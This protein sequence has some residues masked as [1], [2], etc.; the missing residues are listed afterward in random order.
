MS[1]FLTPDEMQ[2]IGR[3]RGKFNAVLHL[4]QV[5]SVDYDIARRLV[6]KYPD[7]VTMVDRMLNEINEMAHMSRA[8]ICVYAAKHKIENFQL[9]SKDQ[10]VDEV[11]KLQHRGVLPMSDEEYAAFR[12]RKYRENNQRNM[13]KRKE[14]PPK[15]VEETAAEPEKPV[16]Q[17]FDKHGFIAKLDAQDKDVAKKAAYE[18]AYNCEVYELSLIE[19]KKVSVLMGLRSRRAI[20]DMYNGCKKEI[21]QILSEGQSGDARAVL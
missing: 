18:L 8:D 7:D 6:E 13:A 21:K 14:K 1:R 4:N 17:L 16:V 5:K 9:M 19:W 3:Q 2:K 15:T 11:L 20:A 12:E 10:I